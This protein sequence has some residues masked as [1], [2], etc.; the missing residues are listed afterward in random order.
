MSIQSPVPFQIVKASEQADHATV[1]TLTHLLRLNTSMISHW[2]T[3][4]IMEMVS[5]QIMQLGSINGSRGKRKGR[6][7]SELAGVYEMAPLHLL[8]LQL[9]HWLLLLFD[10][11][12][13]CLQRSWWRLAF[14]IQEKL[15]IL[16]QTQDLVTVTIEAKKG[17]LGQLKLMIKQER[18]KSKR[19]QNNNVS[20]SG[21]SAQEMDPVN[22]A[23]LEKPLMI[24]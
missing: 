4:P 18:G 17:K 6:M 19:D 11:V 7:A 2:P 23:H 16:L 22:A 24:Q 9:G 15:F 1:S 20:N 3:V 5:Q 8:K 14:Q 21:Y 10:L 13:D 12:G